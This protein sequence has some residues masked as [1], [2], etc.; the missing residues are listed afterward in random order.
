MARQDMGYE[1]QLDENSFFSGHQ[2]ATVATTGKQHQRPQQQ[3]QHQQPQPTMLPSHWFA[4]TAPNFQPSHWQM[5]A[6]QQ[7]QHQQQLYQ[8]Q[9][10]H[11]NNPAGLG[12]EGGDQLLTLYR[13]PMAFFMQQNANDSQLKHKLCLSPPPAPQAPYPL[14]RVC[15]ANSANANAT[16]ATNATPWGGRGDDCWSC[17]SQTTST[18]STPATPLS[19]QKTQRSQRSEERVPR[20]AEQPRPV[21]ALHNGF[22]VLPCT[23]AVRGGGLTMGTPIVRKPRENNNNSILEDNKF[24]QFSNHAWNILP[25]SKSK[26]YT[27]EIPVLQHAPLLDPNEVGKSSVNDEQCLNNK[28]TNRRQRQL[29]FIQHNWRRNA[30]QELRH[31]QLR[32]TVSASELDNTEAAEQETT[33]ASSKAPLGR[34]SWPPMKGTVTLAVERKSFVQK[35]FQLFKQAAWVASAAGVVPA[36]SPMREFNLR[37]ELF[38]LKCSVRH[39]MN[40]LFSWQVRNEREKEGMECLGL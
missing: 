9:Q 1:C 31:K 8:H 29:S 13:S 23:S 20:A 7:Q 15:S 18:C 38:W 39:S 28:T 21:L 36:A 3:W 17:G 5:A 11:N 12:G 30:R 32:Q 10:W 22:P 34:H 4:R 14:R 33:P 16:A 6:S 19:P 26:H 27:K 35:V 40:F 2:L 25:A 24:E 37:A